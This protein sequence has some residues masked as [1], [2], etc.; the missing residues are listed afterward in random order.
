M[1][2]LTTE[3]IDDL[4]TEIESARAEYE[5]VQSGAYDG[6]GS[7]AAAKANLDQTIKNAS[8]AL[9]HDPFANK[10]MAIFKLYS[11]MNVTPSSGVVPL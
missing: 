4:A 8:D 9:S 10:M 1:N 11:V 7:V 3:E 2:E 6:I 5:S